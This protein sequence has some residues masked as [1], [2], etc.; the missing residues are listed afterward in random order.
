MEQPF[1][2]DR[3]SYH[4]SVDD[5]FDCLIEIADRRLAV[6]RHPFF[7][8]LEHLHEDFDARIDLYLFYQKKIDGKLR[9]LKD[10]PEEVRATLNAC[11][12]MR[13]GPHALDY[14]TAPYSQTPEEQVETFQR[15]Y[16]EISR[17]AGES[18]FSQYVRLH[19]FSESY[20]L[21]DFFQKAGVKAL[22]TT[23]KAAVTHRMP[24]G[25]KLDL[26]AKGFAQFQGMHFIRT[27]WR[28]EQLAE[29]HAPPDACARVVTDALARF[30][31][32]VFFSHEDAIA[33]PEVRRHIRSTFR[34]LQEL[35]IPS[36]YDDPDRSVPRGC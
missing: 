34:T 30:Q 21:S 9:T 28:A 7:Q 3:P 26:G 31:S 15:I 4:F 27:H 16:S 8:F 18:R 2:F 36:I 24:A 14:E 33:R 29:A 17:I 11:A 13:F 5:V 19:Y 20:E 25:V 10:I 12:W 23:D 35:H 22:F 32:V 1:L 6:F